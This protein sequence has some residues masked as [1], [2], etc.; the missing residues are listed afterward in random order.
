MKKITLVLSL[1][2]FSL[3]TAQKKGLSG[4]TLIDGYDDW[5]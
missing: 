4:G 1:M 3:M 5:D 2:S